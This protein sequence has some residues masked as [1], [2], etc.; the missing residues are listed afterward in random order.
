MRSLTLE[1]CEA[2]KNRRKELLRLLVDVSFIKKSIIY[3]YKTF[4]IL[5]NIMNLYD[6]GR[7]I[8]EGS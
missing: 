2:Q 5:K 6:L 8:V 1:T 7:K 4:G 3:E